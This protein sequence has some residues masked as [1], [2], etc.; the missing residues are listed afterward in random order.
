MKFSDHLMEPAG[1]LNKLY[2]YLGLELDRANMQVTAKRYLAM[3]IVATFFLFVFL[4]VALTIFLIKIDHPFL[5]VILALVFSVLILFFQINYPKV[6]AGKRIRRLDADLL[7]ALRALMIQ[8]SSGVPMFDAMVI[9][10]RQE[11]GEVSKELRE[12]VKKINAG[13]PQTDALETMALRNPSPYFRR[14][15]WQLVSAMKEGATIKNVIVYV[16]SDL[17]KEQIIQ[18]ERYGA[19]LNPLAMFYMMGAVILPVLVITFAIVVTSFLQLEEFL[20]KVIFFCIL[21]FVCFFQLMFSGIVK[22]KRPSLLGE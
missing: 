14:A 18:I 11:F 4:A 7:G 21:G 5:G 10:S 9:I 8:L 3:C 17:T 13:V 12:V 20:I 15:I 16:I 6:A 19:Q 22:T 2:P 1:K